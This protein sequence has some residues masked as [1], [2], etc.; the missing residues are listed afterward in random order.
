M[1]ES[2]ISGGKTLYK[3]VVSNYLKPPAPATC[4]C[5]H[6]HKV[7][8]GPLARHGL[9][10][11]L[12]WCPK[13]VLLRHLKYSNYVF[14]LCLNPRKPLYR[15]INRFAADPDTISTPELIIGAL[16]ILLETKKI[17]SFTPIEIAK[18]P[19]F[20]KIPNGFTSYKKIVAS[21]SEDDLKLFGSECQRIFDTRLDKG[22]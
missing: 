20:Q 18:S 3:N 8:E 12:A 13:R 11:H 1:S 14:V 17:K 22:E 2:V 19:E 15:A 21:L 10:S 7:F 16:M 6:C 9:N 4:E 5:I